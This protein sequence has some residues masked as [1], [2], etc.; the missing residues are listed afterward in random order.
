LKIYDG[1]DVKMYSLDL[2]PDVVSEFKINYR[3]KSES[4]RLVINNANFDMYTGDLSQYN[5][6]CG[7]C[8]FGM[9]GKTLDDLYV[10]GWDGTS[11]VSQYFGMGVNASIRC[12]ED[13]AMCLMLHRLYTMLWYQAGIEICDEVMNSARNNPII[14]YGKEQAE[15]LKAQFVTE[16]KQAETTFQS[17]LTSYINSFK[18]D[19]LTCKGDT[20]VQATP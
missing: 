14:T 7:F 1:T 16:V 10:T 15:K 3:A 12:Y 4:V 8:S 9:G 20:Y 19:C 18:S 6:K 17:N 11:E 13:K 5:K 2:L